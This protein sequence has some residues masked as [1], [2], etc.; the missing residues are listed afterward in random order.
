MA[1]DSVAAAQL[2]VAPGAPLLRVDRV[3]FTDGDKPV[4]WRRGLCSTEGFSY[5]NE[6]N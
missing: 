6:L 1:A 5:R 2:K 3:A 4:E